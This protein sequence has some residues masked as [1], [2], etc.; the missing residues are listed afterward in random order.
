MKFHYPLPTHFDH[1]SW[2]WSQLFAI[3]KMAVFYGG[4]VLQCNTLKMINP[5]S[6][7]YPRRYG[8]QVAQ[9]LFAS[10]LLYQEDKDLLV[11]NFL[12]NIVSNGE[13]KTYEEGKY[14]ELAKR[15]SERVKK[16]NVIWKNVKFY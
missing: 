1:I 11:D 14:I 2:W 9:R 10:T 7:D 16:D 3:S 5:I 15:A 8:F 12:K 13:V 4:H 6:R